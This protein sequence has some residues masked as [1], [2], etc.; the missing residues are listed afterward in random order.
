MYQNHDTNK[1]IGIAVMANHQ[2]HYIKRNE[3]ILR[4]MR[5]HVFL[6]YKIQTKNATISLQ[7]AGS[8][9]Y[10]YCDVPTQYNANTLGKC[11][12]PIYNLLVINFL[13]VGIYSIVVYSL[14][15]FSARLHLFN[16]DGRLFNAGGRLFNAGGHL[17]NAGG[18]LFNAGRRLFNAGRRLCNAG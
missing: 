7:F 17:F 14:N 18:H 4:S 13:M 2:R 16:A 10:V 6:Y 12:C 5:N 1:P 8:V 3:V 9:G 11:G 15:Y